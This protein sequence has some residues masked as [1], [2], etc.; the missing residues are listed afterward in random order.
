[1]GKVAWGKKTDNA[2]V[3]MIGCDQ[4][5]QIKYSNEREAIAAAERIKKIAI[6]TANFVYGE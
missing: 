6:E 4:I 2:W 3:A 5:G 1:M